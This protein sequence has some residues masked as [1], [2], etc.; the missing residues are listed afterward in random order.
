MPSATS[1]H[2]LNILTPEEIEDLY[3]LPQFTDDDRNLYFDLSPPERSAVDARTTSVGVY[4][5]LEL[6]Y[7]KAKRQ[8]FTF[9]QDAVVDDLRYLLGQYFPGQTIESI[10]APSRPTRG[11]I[12]QAV[13]D[14]FSYRVCDSIA[15][16]ELEQKAQRIAA[17]ST[18][19]E[20]S[21]A[22]SSAR[23]AR[24]IAVPE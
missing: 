6:G 22:I 14:L 21:S 20:A 3:G 24:V 2:R 19:P 11:A 13:L 8:F 5:A 4:L 18:Q 17:L 15:K 12:Q 1:S 23:S 9:D 7:F 16:T 10:K